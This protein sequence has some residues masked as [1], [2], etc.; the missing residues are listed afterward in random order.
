LSTSGSWEGAL[1]PMSATEL[2]ELST[3]NLIDAVVQFEPTGHPLEA[4]RSGLAQQM[5][6]AV[7][8]AGARYSAEAALFLDERLSAE[9]TSAFV[10]GLIGAVVEQEP[11]VPPSPIDWAATVSFCLTLLERVG[12]QGSAGDDSQDIRWTT[13]AGD[14]LRLIELG[15]ADRPDRIPPELLECVRDVLL[16]LANWPTEWDALDPLEM[17]IHPTIREGAIESLI[18]YATRRVK[19]LDLPAASRLEPELKTV[20][21]IALNPSR[22]A[23]L[24][25]HG[26]FGKYYAYL[27]YLDLTWLSAQ[28]PMI[29]PVEPSLAQFWRAAWIQYICSTRLIKS[30][31]LGLDAEYRRAISALGDSAI[32]FNDRDG[33]EATKRLGEALVIAYVSGWESLT[34]P[35]GRLAS[36]LQVAPEY[37]LSR[38]FWLL[39][40]ILRD[41]RPEADSELWSKLQAYWRARVEV[42]RASG[43]PSTELQQVALWLDD[44]PVTLLE[45]KDLLDLSIQNTV[46]GWEVHSVVEYLAEASEAYPLEA[47]QL[48]QRINDS[49]SD[50]LKVGLYGDATKIVRAAL[51]RPNTQATV[52]ARRFASDRADSGDVR[53]IQLLET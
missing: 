1:S 33:Q 23:I 11:L 36:F 42:V 24:R 8:R 14:I 34:D 13:V 2:A 37:S 29:F 40:S 47:M 9:F 26:V 22:E 20:F 43:Y 35:N 7:R 44:I 48:L 45:I 53:Y 15:L 27:A 18:S 12:Q 4:A 6:A 41:R 5:T 31:Y 25:I 19:L 49:T 10:R 51:R 38:M 28:R 30:L 32:A 50:E 21:E 16:L 46:H 3:S 39:G 17:L 52:L